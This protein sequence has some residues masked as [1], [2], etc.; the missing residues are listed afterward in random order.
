MNPLSYEERNKLFKAALSE[1]D[2][3][4]RSKNYDNAFK[5]INKAS[6]F[7]PAFTDHTNYILDLMQI[8]NR[9]A[10]ICAR[11]KNPDYESCLIFTLEVDALDTLN[12]LAAF[13]FLQGFYYRRE[14]QF[15]FKPDDLSDTMGNAL[16]DLKIYDNR[17]D[18]IAEFTKFK[19]DELP[20]IYGIPSKYIEKP[21]RSI[22]IR[23]KEWDELYNRLPNELHQ[24]TIDFAVIEIYNFVTRLI[25]KYHDMGNP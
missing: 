12:D 6:Q 8:K 5:A 18:F 13:P 20:I 7:L 2:D 22:S 16:K 19:Y 17:K 9:A 15:S 10:S 4:Y 23:D 24:K 3:Y 1:S 14:N 25:K 11:D 21:T